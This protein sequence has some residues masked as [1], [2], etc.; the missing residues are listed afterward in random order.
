MKFDYG[1]LLVR[2]FTLRLRGTLY[3]HL[4]NLEKDGEIKFIKRG[5]LKIYTKRGD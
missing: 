5:K 4:K 2:K 3:K 1:I